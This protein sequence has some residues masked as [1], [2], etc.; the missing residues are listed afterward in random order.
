MVNNVRF[1]KLKKQID[2]E[3]WGVVLVTFSQN[4]ITKVISTGKK[5]RRIHFDKFFSKDFKRFSPTTVIDSKGI[6]S[7]IELTINTKNPFNTKKISTD[8][9]ISFIRNEVS[10]IPNLST[11]TTYTYIVESFV[12]FLTSINKQEIPF[13][14]LTF[15]LFRHYKLY[16]DG[17]LSYGSIRY[18]FIVHRSFVA[19]GFEDEKTDLILTLKRFKLEKNAKKS[20]VLNDDDIEKLR[21]VPRSHPLIKFVQFSLMQ[22]FT[23][24]IRFSD[25]LLIKFSDFKPTYL[26]IHQMKTNRILQVLYSPMM[27]DTVYSILKKDYTP[28]LHPYNRGVNIALKDFNIE[29]INEEKQD[30]I[31]NYIRKQEDRFLFDFV[32]PILLKYKKGTDMN[33]EQHKR[34]I[35]HRV[36]YNNHLGKLIKPLELTV[37][38]LSSHS[39]RYA[40]TRIALENEIPLHLLSQSLGHS[41]VVIT[42]NYIRNNFQVENYKIIGEMF[43]T[44]YKN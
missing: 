14:E 34:Y 11:K 44:K 30:A 28:T 31:I 36:N 3:V 27:I 18:Y 13:S 19:K 25:C 40:Y 21:N 4:S 7:E 26:E 1:D 9:Y 6:N 2:G 10:L 24:G 39:M 37:K 16:L 5:I 35:L 43:A 42:E 41:S 15:D 33:E 12:D 38:T 8:G 20:T 29:Y 32:D 23:N 22:L 17:K